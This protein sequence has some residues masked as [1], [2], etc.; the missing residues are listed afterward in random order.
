[1][2]FFEELKRRNVI[3]A[4]MAYIVVAWVLV[5][6]LTIILPEF[7]APGWVLKTLMIL[8]AVGLPIWM[9]FSW[10]Y[11]VTPEGLKKTANVSTDESITSS[12]NKRLNVV[13]LV[14]LIIAI[15]VNFID[16]SE[17]QNPPA[18]ST[19]DSSR[20]NTIAVLPFL[21]MSPNKDQGF[22]S[23]GIAV[24]ILN[25]LC[26]FKELKVVGR[27]SSFSFKNTNEDIKSIGNKLNVN[28][29]LE[30]S[31]QKQQ[32]KIM[33]SVRLTNSNDGYTIFSESYT[34]ELDNIFELQS[35]IAMDIAEKIESNFALGANKLYTRKKIDPLSYETF[36][37]GKLEFVNGPLNMKRDEIFKAKKY[38]ESAIALDSSFAE[39]NAYLSL[40]Y[41]NLADWAISGEESQKREI[42][43]DSGKLLA[44]R[45]LSIDSLSSG[46]HLAMG[47][48][49]FHE[50]NWIQAEKEK[51]QAVAL[52]PGGS[53]EKFML[54]SFLAQFGQADEALELDLEAKKLDPLDE[55]AELKYIRDLFRAENFKEGILRC[56]RLIGEGRAPVGTYQFLWLCHAGLKQYKEAGK[57]FSKYAELIG[58]NEISIIFQENDFKSAIEK[59]F[60]YHREFELQFLIRPII[61]AVFYAY[62]ED[63][64]NTLK[65][66]NETYDKREPQISF[67]RD[68]RFDFMKDDPRYLELYEKAGFKAYDEH[69]K[70]L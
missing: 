25:S 26:K 27:T 64:E 1:M 66:L 2:K 35:E 67:L 58:E 45:A 68:S 18:V 63:K 56:N 5:Q 16:T 36:L 57:A 61:K 37:K 51:R 43:L 62:I 15:A 21:D 29:I 3:K 39:A 69:I 50:Y 42:A 9:I 49:Y 12:T 4:T 7:E 11:E 55:M 40:V 31:V 33:I 70:M 60:A 20:D 22:Y 24:E 48:Y 53:E 17:P 6:V 38:F 34:E 44:K 32:N 23:D 47:S 13:I 46:A 19:N 52:N 41:F 28:N 54:A 65:Y 10:V 59:M 30:G 8:M 14:V